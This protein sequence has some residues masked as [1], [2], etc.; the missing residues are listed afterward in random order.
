[1]DRGVRQSPS[2]PLDAPSRQRRPS[3]E[4]AKD[5]LVDD[6]LVSCFMWASG[7]PGKEANRQ[8][9]NGSKRTLG[10]PAGEYGDGHASASAPG[11]PLQ[12][13]DEPL[14]RGAADYVTQLEA[15]VSTG[16][17]LSHGSSPG[18][19]PP[20]YIPCLH[21]HL[22]LHRRQCSTSDAHHAAAAPLRRRCHYH[23]SPPPPPPPPPS[24][25]PPFTRHPPLPH[26]PPFHLHRPGADAERPALFP[27]GP[28]GHGRRRGGRHDRGESR[29]AAAAPAAAASA[30]AAHGHSRRDQRRWTQAGRMRPLARCGHQAAQA[31]R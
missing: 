21:L 7:E 3:G 11:T 27:P 8:T 19:M 9:S 29:V 24:A 25:P 5:T 10:A 12:H 17:C 20:A 22:L 2:K 18:A 4:A 26:P 16:S 6:E 1:M 23:P 30:P 15:K 13:S 28:H 14:D 31:L